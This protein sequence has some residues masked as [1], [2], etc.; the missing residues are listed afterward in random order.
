MDIPIPTGLFDIL[1]HDPKELWRSSH[2]WNFVEEAIFQLA[3]DYA[4]EEMRTPIFERTELFKRSV[5]DETDIVKKEMYTFLDSGERSMTLRPE[6]TAPAMRSFIE[7][8]LYNEK[9]IHRFF[10]V[11]PM[12]RYERPQSGRYRQHHQFGVELIGVKEAAADAEMIEMLYAL[13][14]RLGLKN[15]TL[16]VNSLGDKETRS[17]FRQALQDYFRPHLENMSDDSKRRF[18][19]NPLRILDSKD[20]LDIPITKKAPSILQFLGAECSD[21]FEAVKEYLNHMSIPFT[22]NDRL[23]RGLDY[24]TKTV[25]EITAGELGA[26]NSIGGGGR[27]DGLIKELG[28]PPLASLGFATGIERLIQ[29]MIAQQVPLP[30]RKRP[31]VM[32]IPLGEAALKA[33]FSLARKMRDKHIKTELDFSGKKLKNALQRASDENISY[34]IVFGDREL[35]A[36]CIELKDMKAKTNITIK[37]GD[38]VDYVLSLKV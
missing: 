27:Y 18:S 36:N 21:H 8:K 24:Y 16:Y 4:L 6:G 38:V 1:P 5:G 9:Q 26:Q 32:I 34:V 3:S 29:T 14:E 19:T 22:I 13:F 20:P 17:A 10:Y 28:G 33:G 15:L 30:E 23:V 31:F 11:G 37:L 12:F 25:F 35:E 2:I 7:K